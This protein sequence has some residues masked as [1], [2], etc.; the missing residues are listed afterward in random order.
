MVKKIYVGNA[1]RHI[2][3]ALTML[4]T[5]G[6]LLWAV[7]ISITPERD[8]SDLNVRWIPSALTGENYAQVLGS[9]STSESYQLA[10]INSLIVAGTT[11]ALALVVGSLGAYAFARL[12]F[13]MKDSVSVLFLIT[14]MIPAIAIALPIYIIFRNMGLLDTRLSLILAN[15][16]FTLP[17]TIWV[18]RSFFTTIPKELEEAGFIDGLG[19]LGALIRI[20]LPLSA[21]GLFATGVF[22]F[23]NTWNEFT[24][25]LVLTGSDQS[26]TMPVAINE[27]LGRF[28]IDYGVMS[29]SGIIGL[30]P[31]VVL[32]LLFQRYLVEGLTSGSIKG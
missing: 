18:M 23:L 2:A 31:P 25:S 27:F 19:R 32:A 16:S 21:P 7:L 9:S 1:L 28:S 13:P 11:T 26:K 30:L 14:Q 3:I 15:L 22:A 24:I 8:L 6:P 4:F 10:L 5:I 12:R 20:V 17:F 29:A